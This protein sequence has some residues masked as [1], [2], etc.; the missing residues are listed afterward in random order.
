M[1]PSHHYSCTAFCAMMELG[2]EIQLGWLVT[3]VLC[4]LSVERKNVIV[5]GYLYSLGAGSENS[6][7][8]QDPH[9]AFGRGPMTPTAEAVGLRLG[10]WHVFYGQFPHMHCPLRHCKGFCVVLED[11][12]IGDPARHNRSCQRDDFSLADRNNRQKR[13]ICWAKTGQQES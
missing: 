8:G 13:T 4:S 7:Y 1:K 12:P 9:E 2:N 11:F 3:H 10:S 6:A 5:R